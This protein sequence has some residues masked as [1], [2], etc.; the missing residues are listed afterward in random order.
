MASVPSAKQIRALPLVPGRMS[1]SAVRGRNCVGERA[2][3]RIGG[4]REREVCK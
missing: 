4:C 1:V 2:S 3:G